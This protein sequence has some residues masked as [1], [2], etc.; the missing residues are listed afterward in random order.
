MRTLYVFGVIAAIAILGAANRVKD[1]EPPTISCSFSASIR[2][3]VVLGDGST[4]VTDYEHFSV[5]TK[6]FLQSGMVMDWFPRN[7]TALFVNPD[8][9]TFIQPFFDRKICATIPFRSIIP[10]FLLDKNSTKVASHVPCPTDPTK[11]CDT[12]KYQDSEV[13]N[14]R[15]GSDPA[16]VDQIIVKDT[17]LNMKV[18]SFFRKFDPH[19]PDESVFAIPKDQPCANLINEPTADDLPK[20]FHHHGR[21]HHHHHAHHHHAHHHHHGHGKPRQMRRI[22]TFL[23]FALSA[24]SIYSTETMRQAAHDAP[25]RHARTHAPEILIAR[26]GRP[27]HVGSVLGGASRRRPA[28]VEAIA[29]LAQPW[30]VGDPIPEA[31]DATVEHANCSMDVIVDQ[32]SCSASWAIAAAQTFGDRFCVAKGAAMRF[33]PQWMVSCH[34]EQLDC[35]GGFGDKAFMDLA[36]YGVVTEQCMPYKAAAEKCPFTCRDGSAL[37]V[38]KLASAY[39]PY[40]RNNVAATVAEIQTDILLRGPVTAGLWTFQDFR[41]Y[42]GGVYEHRSSSGVIAQH[43]VRI[44]GWGVDAATHKPYWKVANSWGPNWGENGYF[45]ILRGSNECAIEDQ[46]ASGSF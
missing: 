29:P 13:W 22:E 23:P 9:Y 11:Y 5:A 46:V 3:Q 19:A 8:R 12:W 39:S 37:A 14:I 20:K 40:K 38:Y 25:R 31:Y 43:T 10:C 36:K 24:D 16:V 6:K 1:E 42:K 44:V 17:E 27:V 18:T 2:S 35:R 32:G 21:H 15:S 30:R 45:R 28:P 26:P 4:R 34:N 33:S 7:M 41:D